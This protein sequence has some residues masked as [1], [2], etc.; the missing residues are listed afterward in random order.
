MVKIIPLHGNNKPISSNIINI[1]GESYEICVEED[2]FIFSILIYRHHT[3]NWVNKL[4]RLTKNNRIINFLEKEFCSNCVT[5]HILLV[6]EE[7][8]ILQQLIN[9]LKSEQ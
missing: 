7:Y 1:N 4:M 5:K 3:P 9:I 6:T 8:H 2:S